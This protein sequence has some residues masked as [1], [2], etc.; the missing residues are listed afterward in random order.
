MLHPES[1]IFR[2]SEA[3][4]DLDTRNMCKIYFDGKSY[5]L[6]YPAISILGLLQ[7]PRPLGDLV[8]LVILNSDS[9]LFVRDVIADV[10]NLIQIGVIS[11][12]PKHGFSTRSWPDGGYDSAYVHL[13]MLNDRSR[14]SAF[15]KAVR[16]SVNANDVVIDLGSGSGILAIAAAQAGAAKVYAVEP[17][18]MIGLARLNAK[19]NG[20]D[21]K[22][23]FIQEWSTTL[24]LPEKATMLTTDLIGN[25]PLDM[26]LWETI[27]DARTRLM[28]SDAKI[29][30]QSFQC[31]ATFYEAP[32]DYI[33][34]HQAS[35]ADV[36]RWFIWYG[37]DFSPLV[38]HDDRAWIGTHERPEIIS[39][40][41]KLSNPVK[42]YCC[43]LSNKCEPF[44]SKVTVDKFP[45]D[46]NAIVL[47]YSARLSENVV[48][49]ASPES[50]SKFSHWYS[51][52]WVRG[53][54]VP[55]FASTQNLCLAYHYR[56]DGSSFLELKEQDEAC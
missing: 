4:I 9:K 8:K 39:G 15:V 36:D 29:I 14:K 51:A 37:I 55:N 30:P 50:G 54:N 25:E 10:V 46:T 22:I 53:L 38:S 42:L 32:N 2:T 18:G 1:L 20:V 3:L 56:G 47:T 28:T 44:T 43:Q 23:T 34:Q 52:V 33:S 16:E 13:R 11:T 31:F 5:S 17:S 49:G 6:G 19:A 24:T 40:W 26:K 35:K 7:R 27:E 41:K 45:C 12:E 48:F 21:E